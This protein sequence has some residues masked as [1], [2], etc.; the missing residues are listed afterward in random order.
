MKRVENLRNL[1]SSHGVDGVLITKAENRRYTTGFTGSAGFVV[2]SK[3]RNVLITDFRYIEQAQEQAPDF[4]I[5][6]GSKD[7]VA[8]AREIVEELGIKNLGFEIMGLSYYEYREFDKKLSD[9]TDMKPLEGIVEKLRVVKDEDEIA[10]IQ[11]AAD[12]ADAAF[13]HILTVIKPGM[14]ELEISLELEYFMKK[15][16]SS[17]NAFDIILASGPRSSLP[18]GIA[19]DR[20][21]QP[22]EFVKMDFG[23]IYKGY[24]SDIT[25]TVVVGEANDKMLE[26][27][28]IVKEAQQNVLDNV[29]AGMSTAEV[30]ALARDIIAE[31][32][33]GDNFGHGLGH[34]I[35]L[36]IHEGPRVGIKDPVVLKENMVITV[37]P[38][39]YIPQF[40]GVRI[41][42]DVVITKD[43]CRILT[44]S[45]KELIKL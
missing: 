4:Q 5:V 1:F 26:I 24:H 45:P 40:G 35:G 16:G 34:G 28:N 7:M 20:I 12:I 8:K 2:I 3:E 39:I 13:E 42:D 27:Y 30:D 23:A 25:R 29:K 37:E 36:E 31:H 43:G 21:I 41:E 17:K 10:L 38:G 33:Y 44:T 18:H 22:N 6:D 15:Q 14:S 11:K 9:I 32:G 19:S